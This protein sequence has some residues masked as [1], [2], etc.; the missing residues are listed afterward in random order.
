[1]GEYA[2]RLRR[3]LA[4]GANDLPTKEPERRPG[5]PLPGGIKD[6]QTLINE[7]YDPFHAVYVFIHSMTARFAEHALPIA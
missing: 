2:K 7:G 1:M 6:I 3:K 5:E 4:S